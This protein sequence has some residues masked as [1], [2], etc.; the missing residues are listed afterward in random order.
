MGRSGHGLR[1]RSSIFGQFMG[2]GIIGRLH[3]VWWAA[4]MAGNAA[5]TISVDISM[6]RPTR[7]IINLDHLRHNFSLARGYAGQASIIAVIKADAYGHG[8]LRI[9]R[10]LLANSDGGMDRKRSGIHPEAFAVASLEEALELRAGGI[11]QRIVLLEGFF[12]ASELDIIVHEG[13]DIVV[14]CQRQLEQ[15][16]M[17]SFAGRAG[18]SQINVWLK[19]DTG[20]QRLGLLPDE[21]ARAYRELDASENVGELRLISHFACADTPE[22]SANREQV[23]VFASAFKALRNRG[24][25]TSLAN[26]AALVAL[27]TALQT[28]N[29]KLSA[30]EIIGDW[31]RPGIMLYGANPMASEHPIADELLPVMTLSSRIIS[32]R[33]LKPGESTGYGKGWVAD[34]PMRVGIVAVGYGDG[35]PRHAPTGTPVLVAGKPSR[36]LGRVSMDMIAV[37]LS[38]LP[39]CGDGDPVTLWGEG[40]PVEEVAGHAGTISY[41]LLTGVTRR[42]AVEVVE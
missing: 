9:A 29:R 16:T 33:I 12:D 39:D 34:R 40:L 27:P 13:L 7:T 1:E 14:H 19:V 3:R 15:L 28:N 6:G 11:R 5:T 17:A 2:A 25:E 32:T 42:V 30:R 8:A 24:L 38:E 22:Q 21:L 35:Y 36:L 18:S 20:M 26:S 37:D 23:E 31:V 41:Q 10:A 4:T